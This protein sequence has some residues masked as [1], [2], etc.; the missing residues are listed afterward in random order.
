MNEIKQFARYCHRVVFNT[1]RLIKNKGLYDAQSYYPE[2]ADRR[3]SKIQRFCNQFVS[4]LKTGVPEDFYFLYGFDIKGFRKRDEYFNWNLLIYKRNEQNFKHRVNHAC[5]LRQKA[6]F[7]LFAETYN[8][9]TPHNFGILRN[10]VFYDFEQ[11]KNVAFDDF[12]TNR[13]SDMFLKLIDGENANGVYHLKA[14]NNKAY[15]N[16]EEVDISEFIKTLNGSA[17]L[18]QERIPAQHPA[19]NRLHPHAIN[20]LRIITIKDEK[21]GNITNYPPLLRVGTGHSHVDN[22]ATGG[23][24]I[25]VDAE[26]KCL[27]KYGFF[28]PYYGTKAS[29]H[30]DSGIVFEGYQIPYLDEAIEMSKRFHRLLPTIQSIG[31]D[32]AITEQGPIFIEGNDNWE[33]SLIQACSYGLKNEFAK[34]FK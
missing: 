13:N 20:T 5:I 28:K 23:L 19:I 26:K 31:W 24:A 15:I 17:Y 29:V 8:I 9:P 4:I 21:T 3:K 22:W 25:G 7:G 18:L 16:S 6:L 1:S 12:L 34:Y 33:I 27:R 30:P 14:E 2:L 32:V 11:K 10:G